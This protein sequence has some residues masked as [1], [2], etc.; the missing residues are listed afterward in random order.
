MKR[1]RGGGAVG[2]AHA[3][4]ASDLWARY[5]AYVAAAPVERMKARSHVGLRKA[6]CSK[7]RC[8]GGRLMLLGWLVVV[9]SGLKLIW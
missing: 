1:R 5:S 7:G 4:T 9:V 3:A 8:E 6:A 2:T